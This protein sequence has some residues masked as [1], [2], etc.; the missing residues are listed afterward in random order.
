MADTSPKESMVCSC[1]YRFALNPK[2]PPN[3]S[4][5]AFQKSLDR[6]TGSGQYYFT[7]TQLYAQIY[8]FLENRLRTTRRASAIGGSGFFL[9]VA[10]GVVFGAGMPWII[11]LPFLLIIVGALWFATRRVK[12][13]STTVTKTIDTY[14]KLH[15]LDN[16]ADGS[17]FKD[18]KPEQLDKEILQYA[19]ERIL[20]VQH[21]DITDMLL[22]NRFHFDNKALV[23]SAQK[24]PHHA[25]QACQSF[26]SQ[27]PDIP[28]LLLHDAST[29]GL[30]MK[31][32]LLTD[33]SWNLQGKNVHD[34]GLNPSG[35]D[36]IKSPIWVPS[37]KEALREGVKVPGVAAPE[38]KIRQGFRVP[39]D[40][41][42]PGAVM[43]AM[44]LSM[45]AM[46]PLLSEQFMAQQQEAA[47]GGGWGGGFG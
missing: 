19:P 5:I 14:E 13:D 36:R 44:A 47:A 11:V 8:R 26:L 21:D 35:V 33:P 43:G 37:T 6:L 41:A 40:I 2:E 18:A 4:D 22:L 15:P 3:I 10:A 42:P 30:H 32:R 28:V 23:L 1:G 16:L 24:Y 7:Y 39:V 17:R 12:L 45:V 20:I 38:E 34:L 29:E 25:F 46:A 27:H 31:E 9:I